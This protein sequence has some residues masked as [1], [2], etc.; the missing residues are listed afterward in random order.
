MASFREFFTPARTITKLGAIKFPAN[1]FQE[2][3]RTPH[4]EMDMALQIYETRPLVNS[5]VK[6]LARF[7]CGDKI[8]I[9]SK[10]PKTQ[11]F[12]Q[13]WLKARAQLDSEVFHMAISG[14][15]TGNIFC[16]RTWKEMTNKSY[17]LDNLYNIN[18]VSRVYINLDFKGVDE[19]YW[20]YEVP[21]EVR[22]FPF[23]GEMK[24]PKFYKVNYVYGSYLFQKMIW[25]IPIHK[26]KIAHQKFGWSRDGLYGRSFLASCI[27][28][29]EILTQILQN[30]STIAR[31]RAIGRKIFTIGAPEDPA[32]IDDIDKLQIDLKNVTDADHLIVN[33]PIKSEPL[34]YS[35]ETDPMTDEI[36]FL[37]RDIASG[38]VP[39]YLTAWNDE[40]NKATAGEVKIPFQLEI[41]S[42]RSDFIQ[43]LN[44]II[45]K[46]LKKQ[47]PWLADDATF[48]FGILDL[49]SKEDRMT[50]GNTLYTN[51]GITLNELRKLAGYQPVEG[52]DKFSNQMALPEPQSGSPTPIPT[53][54]TGEGFKEAISDEDAKWL[55]GM[56][57]GKSFFP[58]KNPTIARAVNIN[59]RRI[60]LVKYDG[61]YAVYDGKVQG[62]DNPYLEVANI[63]FDKLKSER[64]KALDVFY[65]KE[66]PED[67][68]ANE[69]FDEVKRLNAEIID[70]VFKE[71]K[72]SKVKIEKLYKE[73]NK[74]DSNMLPKLTDIFSKFDAKINE[75][76]NR[77]S[78]KLFGHAIGKTS[79]FGQDVEAD[80]STKN[81][82]NLQA[83][84]LKGRMNNELKTM[85]GNMKNDFFRTLSDGL[86]SGTEPSVMQAQLKDKYASYKVKENPQDWQIERVVRT[87]LNH[88][89]TMMRLQKW[90]NMGF[91]KVEHIT[92][93]D[94]VTGEKDRKFNHRIFDINYLLNT[95]ADR[96]PLHPNCR[97][98]YAAYE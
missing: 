66:T 68:I 46:E 28:D 61:G 26:S 14:L 83:D 4:Y 85:N 1:I 7:I 56:K 22:V 17:V 13:D 78:M 95:P 98:L 2:Q 67:L 43:F 91:E 31:Y 32:G 29:G 23:M 81:I 48:S 76:V 12:Y 36:Q 53:D 75:I 96:I 38:I 77:I 39:N 20:L 69:M 6:Q 93:I 9:T 55:S 37:R 41:Q 64:Q 80:D 72:K 24:T 73:Q 25:A 89:S 45:L 84:V 15:C 92:V 86:A 70:E 82:L 63:F 35:G 34:S 8:T 88:A 30:Y 3:K 27:D 11:T 18:D 21:I 5:G 16:E 44:R 97:C 10:D 90:K 87:E 94:E 65:D 52:G 58:G 57:K 19:E 62:I 33:K 60:R 51:N 59:G 79:L 54:L 50:W 42:F 71:I 40:T 49:D 74:L 47:Y